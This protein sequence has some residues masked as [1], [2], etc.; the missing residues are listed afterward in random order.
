M[1]K[2]KQLS[3]FHFYSR[4]LVRKTK[5]DGSSGVKKPDLQFTINPKYRQLCTRVISE[6]PLIKKN[7]DSLLV[8]SRMPQATPPRRTLFFE[9]NFLARSNRIA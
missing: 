5:R 9:S 2:L 3:P 4:R 6:R 1:Y 8:D 7:E